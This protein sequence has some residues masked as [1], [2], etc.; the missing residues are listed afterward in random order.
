MTDANI[1]RLLWER[2][3]SAILE[4]AARFEQRLQ[5]TAM[6]ILDSFPDA[7]EVVND[8]YLAVW[9]AVPPKEPAPLSGF[10]YSIGRNLALKKRRSTT[11]LKRRSTYDLSLEE[12]EGCIPGSA[13]EA[14]VETR[15][16]GADI[17]RF[18]STISRENRVIFLRRYWFGDGVKDI[19]K[20]LGMSE[21]TVSARLS[22]TRAGLR[23]YLIKE[24]YLDE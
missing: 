3:E 24:G 19:A 8:T 23:K 10:V 12:L 14:A 9:N 5:A 21:N 2:S 1:I 4:L 18:L 7:E 17:D 16:L 11:A 20:A 13:L 22:R 6:H 15:A